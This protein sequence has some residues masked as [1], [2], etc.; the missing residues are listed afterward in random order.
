MGGAKL[1]RHHSGNQYQMKMSGQFYTP[2]TL[3][4]VGGD[5]E[6]RAVAGNWTTQY[7]LTR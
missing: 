4:S 6:N 1:R 7:S 2:D 3:H 5:D